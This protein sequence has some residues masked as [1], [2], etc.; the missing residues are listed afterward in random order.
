[1]WFE[2]S[3]DFCQCNVIWNNQ[4]NIFVDPIDAK[5]VRVS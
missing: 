2:N 3:I 5:E 1:M 4:Q